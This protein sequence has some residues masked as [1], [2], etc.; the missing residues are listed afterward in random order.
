MPVNEKYSPTPLWPELGP[1]FYDPVEAARF[2]KGILR[3]RNQEWATR[4]GLDSLTEQEWKKAFWGK[5]KRPGTTPASN[6]N[7]A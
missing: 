3:Y 2:P 4:V 1:D 7:Y 6:E 5:E